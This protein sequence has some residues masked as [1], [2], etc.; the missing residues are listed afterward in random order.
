MNLL[1]RFTFLNIPEFEYSLIPLK[2]LLVFNARLQ[3]NNFFIFQYDLIDILNFRLVQSSYRFFG[4]YVNVIR[5][6][7]NRSFSALTFRLGIYISLIV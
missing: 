3:Y 7:E 5:S 4:S 1:P 6:A 2:M